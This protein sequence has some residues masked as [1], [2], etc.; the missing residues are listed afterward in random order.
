VRPGAA[1][2]GGLRRNDENYNKGR[3]LNSPETRR[4]I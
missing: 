3:I 1:G 4:E 2:K